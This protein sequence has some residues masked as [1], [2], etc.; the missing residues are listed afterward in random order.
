VGNGATAILAGI[1]SQVLEDR[2]GQIG[3]FQGAIA[4][5]VLA[6]LMILP[7]NENYGENK[8]NK[9]TSLYQQFSQ[10]WKTTLSNSHVWKIGMT[11]ALSEGAMY[12]VCSSCCF[13]FVWTKES[14]FLIYLS[15]VCTVCIHVGANSAFL[16]PSRW[17]SHRMRVFFINDRNHHWWNV[18]SRVASFLL[19][20]FDDWPLCS[21]SVCIVCVLTCGRKHGC[22]RFLSLSSVIPRESNH[23]GC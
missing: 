19:E 17:A 14:H 13:S 8:D 10:G 9:S 12:T 16:G 11:Q 18:V 1:I 3:P 2:F 21:R 20:V 7:W 4:L 6:L 23:H 5:T 15:P 22:P